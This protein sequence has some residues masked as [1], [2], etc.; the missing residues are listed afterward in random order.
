MKCTA[1]TAATASEQP[2]RHRQ[3]SHLGTPTS[4]RQAARCEVQHSGEVAPATFHLTY[5]PSLCCPGGLAFDRR[6]FLPDRSFSA[7]SLLFD[8]FPDSLSSKRYG[9]TLSHAQKHV[10]ETSR[11]KPAQRTTDMETDA[12]ARGSGVAVPT[13]SSLP[14][15]KSQDCL[16]PSLGTPMALQFFTLWLLHAT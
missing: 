7:H 15:L 9:L 1:A 14:R 10:F 11:R 8:C 12:T 2:H 13:V 6:S 5:L 3:T 16:V 4:S